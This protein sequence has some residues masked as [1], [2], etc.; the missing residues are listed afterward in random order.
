[1][2]FSA[3]E[4]IRAAGLDNARLAEALP[5]VDP[6]TVPVWR[7]AGW[8]RLFWFKGIRA[9]TMPWG[10]YLAPEVLERAPADIGPLLVHELAHLEQWRRLGPSFPCRRCRSAT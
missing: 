10:V 5:R 7:A 8:F 1:M 9:V 4:P 2:R 3:A 6:S